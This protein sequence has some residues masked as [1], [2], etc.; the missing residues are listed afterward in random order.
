MHISPS[1]EK[2]GKIFRRRKKSGDDHQ[3]MKV[4]SS[5]APLKLSSPP[6]PIRQDS[7]GVAPVMASAAKQEKDWELEETAGTKQEEAEAM[8]SNDGQGECQASS[9]MASSQKPGPAPAEQGS[10]PIVPSEEASVLDSQSALSRARSTS[11]IRRASPSAIVR[12][13]A[14]EERSNAQLHRIMSEAPTLRYQQLCGGQEELTLEQ[15]RISI[16]LGTHDTTLLDCIFGALD[17]DNS[18]ALSQKEFVV[19]LDLLVNG[20]FED[21]VDFQ[22]NLYDVDGDGILSK[23][24]FMALS[25]SI[26]L[27]A[28]AARQKA[29]NAWMQRISTSCGVGE[30]GYE[31]ETMWSQLWA[32]SGSNSAEE[33]FDRID[34]DHDDVLSLHEFTNYCKDD[35]KAI[36]SVKEYAEYLLR[37][38]LPYLGESKKQSTFQMMAMLY[39]INRK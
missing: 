16:G 37:G 7:R 26:F 10:Q 19:G 32:Q 1:K 36:S 28:Q 17:V 35:P 6:K 25:R 33:K 9:S 12:L 38:T 8:E 18:G 39:G 14:A 30:G 13:A 23:S 4:E 34:V 31:M 22:F 3:Q 2:K 5:A 11:V 21:Q 15:L 24:D 27:S 29:A 20:S